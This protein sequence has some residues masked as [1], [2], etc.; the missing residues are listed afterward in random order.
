MINASRENDIK[1]WPLWL[2]VF[3]WL[4]VAAFL[5]SYLTGDDYRSVHVWAGYL[6]IGLLL[7]RIVLG[8]FSSGYASLRGW[9]CSPRAA[10]AYLGGLLRGTSPRYLGHN[11]AGACMSMAL[12][13]SLGVTL[14]TGLALHG[15]HGSGPLATIMS[16]QPT[17]ADAG[18]S[19][20]GH[21]ESD[22][23]GDDHDDERGEDAAEEF[24]EELHEL[25][26]NI[27]LALVILHILG[28]LASS[29]RHGE[30]LPKSMVTGRKK[31]EP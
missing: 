11:P 29:W 6:I 23:H 12:M 28:V 14:G 19:A 26:V 17:A 25:F 18:I 7:L 24:W 9:R 13:L 8:L 31:S 20:T 2:R 15:V 27:S 1:V 4:L 3:H 21:R 22:E 10:M 5:V 30:N 16:A